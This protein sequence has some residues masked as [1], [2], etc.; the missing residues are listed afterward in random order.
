M[1]IT[2]L[3]SFTGKVLVFYMRD[4]HGKLI[5]NKKERSLI[6]ELCEKGVIGVKWYFLLS[7]LAKCSIQYG[8]RI[9]HNTLQHRTTHK[10]A[11]ANSRKPKNTLWAAFR[12]FRFYAVY[13]SSLSLLSN[14]SY[15]N[16]LTQVLFSN[17][18][19]L[20]CYFK[21]RIHAIVYMVLTCT[22]TF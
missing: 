22:W 19:D 5:K 16:Q 8:L 13:Y 17:V 6:S 21:K 3:Q 1:Y 15:T 12:L 4:T 7:R 14:E 11:K 2:T 18:Y 10:L 9:F 20:K